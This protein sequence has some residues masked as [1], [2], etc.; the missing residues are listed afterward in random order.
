MGSTFK[1]FL[2]ESNLQR[3]CKLFPGI[4]QIKLITKNFSDY[5]LNYGIVRAT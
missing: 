1:L 2:F 3:F 4:Y 5:R